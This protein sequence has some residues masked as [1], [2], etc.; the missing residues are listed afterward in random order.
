MAKE[1]SSG[2]I[3]FGQG[4]PDYQ[5]ILVERSETQAEGDEDVGGE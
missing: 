4:C 5:L 2:V 1:G 3:D